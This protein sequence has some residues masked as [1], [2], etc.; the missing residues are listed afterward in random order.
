MTLL[1]LDRDS[2][3]SLLIAARRRLRG[4]PIEPAGDRLDD[5]RLFRW[6]KLSPALDAVPLR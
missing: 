2:D 4:L 6:R 3:K 1:P 5:V